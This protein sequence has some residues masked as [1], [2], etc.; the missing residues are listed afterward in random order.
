M[1]RK[2]TADTAM[3]YALCLLLCLLAAAGGCEKS[4]TTASDLVTVKRYQSTDTPIAAWE[5][6]N[7]ST[8]TISDSGI[9]RKIEYS[10][11]T[12]YTWT[13]WLN[14]WLAHS[15]REEY[16]R[17]DP[18]PT[19]YRAT[20]DMFNGLEMKGDWT[21]DI[22]LTDLPRPTKRYDRKLWIGSVKKAAYPSA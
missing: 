18:T 1:T 20:T 4:P 3:S 7:T 16:V 12:R 21:L 2:V 13:D 9:V 17:E 8:I 11:S 22:K 15:A 10:L 6:T 19:S 5:S 14:L